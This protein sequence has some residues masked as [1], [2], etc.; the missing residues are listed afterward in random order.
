MKNQEIGSRLRMMDPAVRC[1][2]IFGRTAIVAS[3]QDST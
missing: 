3:S 2:V 1:L